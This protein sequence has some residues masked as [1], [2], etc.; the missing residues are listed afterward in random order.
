[1]EIDLGKKPFKKFTRPALE[2]MLEEMI[3][4]ELDKQ[5]PRHKRG[6]E[7]QEKDDNDA[8]QDEERNKLA[9]LVEEKR[10]KSN[11]VGMDD[12]DMSDDSVGDLKEAVNVKPKDSKKDE[13]KKKPPKKK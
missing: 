11:E 9:D 4:K 2:E 3:A 5:K 8:E 6:E 7:R 1:M 12:E 13:G 10:G